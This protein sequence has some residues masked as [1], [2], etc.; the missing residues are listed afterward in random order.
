MIIS[1]VN[2]KGGVGK[3]TA[4]INL[5]A[6]LKRKNYNVAFVD[7]D[8]QGSA[9]TWH[10][11]ENNNI[12]EIM[13]YPEPVSKSDIGALSQDYDY[14]VIDAPP[15]IGDIAKSVL[16]VSDLSI[17][18]LSPSSLDIWSCKGTLEMID[19]AQQ[20]NP[21]LDV[22]LLINRKIPGTRVGREAR[23][24][25]AIFNKEILDTEICQRV[26]YID[27]MASGVSVMQYAPSSK[28]ALEIENL[29]DELTFQEVE[30][31]SEMQVEME[32]ELQVEAESEMHVEA[33]SE[34]QVE[35][36]SE[37]QVEEEPE[38]QEPYSYAESAGGYDDRRLW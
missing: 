6:S 23:E 25:L 14:L 20:E 35:A 29:C 15:G 4:A 2:Q 21:D 7:A 5:A 38:V 13:H 28:A 37:V 34:M 1:F 27:A 11:I 26:A 9:T 32:P 24:A 22:K 36:E 30:A 19:E 31:A 17:I 10:S 16:S 18:P 8:P 12:F 3:T 33:E